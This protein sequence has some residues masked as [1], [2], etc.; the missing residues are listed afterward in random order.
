MTKKEEG[1]LR[2]EG[3]GRQGEV[4]ESDEQEMKKGEEECRER[5]GERSKY[6]KKKKNMKKGMVEEEG[7]E[8]GL[9]IS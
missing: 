9:E 6:G 3:K 5:R 2:K 7:K 1:K 8:E 4:S